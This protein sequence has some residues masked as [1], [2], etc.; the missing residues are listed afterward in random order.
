[1]YP[2]HIRNRCF[3]V[4]HQPLSTQPIFFSGHVYW[5]FQTKCLKSPGKHFNLKSAF[6]LCNMK[7][8]FCV[9]PS[10]RFLLWHSCQDWTVL[11]LEFSLFPGLWSL[12]IETASLHQ[13]FL[14]I[15]VQIK[16][17]KQYPLLNR[18][19]PQILRAQNWWFQR[20]DQK[21]FGLLEK[22]ALAPSFCTFFSFF[23]SP[24]LPTGLLKQ[25]PYDPR[26]VLATLHTLSV[27][28]FASLYLWRLY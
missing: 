7:V 5:N 24:V 28:Q 22:E 2:K 23:T 11:H 18:S 19:M 20:Q 1:M 6:L 9:T 14:R 12:D 21:A 8:A 4:S 3:F 26:E 15:R 17:G 27:N 25:K 16:K 10:H 13:T